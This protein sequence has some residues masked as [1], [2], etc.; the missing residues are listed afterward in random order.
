MWSLH[1]CLKG[2]K[3]QPLLSCTQK[4]YQCKILPPGCPSVALFYRAWSSQMKTALEQGA[5][6][7]YVHLRREGDS[8]GR[9]HLLSTIQLGPIRGH[10]FYAGQPKTCRKCG[11][12]THLA[13]N[14][15]TT[16]CWNCHSAD[17]I[18]KDCDQPR[19]CNLCNSST[20]TF[21]SCPRSYANH[22]RQSASIDNTETP[23]AEE[24]QAPEGPGPSNKTQPGPDDPPSADQHPGPPNAH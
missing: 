14:C 21:Q 12:A 13:A 1:H 15:T 8:G 5:R 17:H 19:R 16:V 10:I 20:H 23:L 9:H 4:R 6:R 18:T 3:R 7:F 24:Q 11:S 22:A 2:S